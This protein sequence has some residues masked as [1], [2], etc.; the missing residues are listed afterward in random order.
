MSYTLAQY[1]RDSGVR[2]DLEFAEK[3]SMSFEP[4]PHQKTG[5][6]RALINTKFGLY[7]ECDTGKTCVMQAYAM[8]YA[9]QGCKV[10]GVMLPVLIPQFEKSLYSTFVGS[11]EHFVVEGFNHSP[12]KREQLRA[13][14]MK[15]NS[16]PDILLISYQL[17][18][19]EYQNLKALG[20]EVFLADEADVM[21]NPETMANK[22]MGLAT[23]DPETPLLNATGTPNRKELIDC[24]GLIKLTNP[25]AYESMGHFERLHVEYY[26]NADTG[27]KIILGYQ[28][29]PLLHKN[30]YAKA[31]RV[32]KESIGRNARPRVNTVSIELSPEHYALYKKV[33]KQRILEVDGEI[34]DGVT[35]QALRQI[36]MRLVTT[37][38]RYLDK[39]VTVK[40]TVLE[41]IDVILNCADVKTENKVILFAHYNSTVESLVDR[42]RHLNPSI[43]YG[44]NSPKHEKE[45]T[46]FINDNTSRLLIANAMSAGVGV[47]GFQHVCNKEVFIEPQATPRTFIQAVE[48]VNRRGQKYTCNIS[49]LEVLRTLYPQRISVMLERNERIKN[50]NQDKYSF[51]DELYGKVNSKK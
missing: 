46:K 48:R 4:D 43:M 47:D 51:L 12:A 18:I 36:A 29:E 38:Q 42:Y 3:I 24:Y 21:C 50:V 11:E 13:E 35:A 1:Y 17:F 20:Y 33:L 49:I 22:V 31:R 27:E 5:L 41:A 30:L 16:A 14:W 23:Q 7:D 28:D 45:K 37:P 26:K 10:V 15:N 19:K 2:C 44:K 8:F 39:N 40:N 9:S 34:I 32:T 25:T 6:N